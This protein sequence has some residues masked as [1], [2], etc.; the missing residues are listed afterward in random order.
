MAQG[1]FDLTDS[2]FND[3]VNES[4][5][6]L[7][8]NQSRLTVSSANLD[9]LNNLYDDPAGVNGWIQIWPKS[10]SINQRTQTITSRKDTLRVDIT[11]ILRIIYKDIPESVLIKDDRDVLRIFERDAVPTERAAIETSPFVDLKTLDG[12]NVKFTC[13][14]VKKNK[15]AS[16]HKRSEEHT[17]ELQS[18]SFI[19]YAVFCLK[20]KNKIAEHTDTEG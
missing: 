6:Y 12:A 2:E 17:S 15:R 10:Q 1:N 3:F 14:V 11:E 19:S 8:T 13:R 5:P 4:V 7:V 20:K 9:T 18:H 16:K